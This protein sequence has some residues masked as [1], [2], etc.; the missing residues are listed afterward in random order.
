M[1]FMILNWIQTHMRCDFLDFIF[2]H[3]TMLGNGG[4]IWIF[5]CV[6]LLFTKRY[7][8]AGIFILLAMLTG[9]LLGEQ[10][11][12]PL[13][14]RPRPFI[15]QSFDLIIPAPSGY[16]FPSGH[17]ASSFCAALFLT[18]LNRRF[19]LPAYL[20]A[21]AIAFSRMYLYVHFPTDVLAGIILG[22]VCALIFYYLYIYNKKTS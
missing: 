13:I 16:S 6:L 15:Q 22:S 11:I 14:A 12:K 5:I 7:R 20:L 19:A 17:T 1:D 18:L 3:I 8:K 2:S 4:L 10:I 9:N 21:V